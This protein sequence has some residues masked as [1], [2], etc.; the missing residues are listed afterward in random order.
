MLDLKR[1]PIPHPLCEPGRFSC[2]KVSEPDVSL[3]ITALSESRSYV[4]D[5]QMMSR[6]NSLNTSS[7]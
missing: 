7:R 4:S 3:D 6:S 2:V 1:T 5:R